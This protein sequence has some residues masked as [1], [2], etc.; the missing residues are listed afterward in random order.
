MD[1]LSSFSQMCIRPNFSDF[2]LR[3]CIIDLP[4]SARSQWSEAS[5]FSD[6]KV[7]VRP[8]F[9]EVAALI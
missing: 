9:T 8:R 5:Q 2:Y 3:G 1:E 6:E 7:T 4:I